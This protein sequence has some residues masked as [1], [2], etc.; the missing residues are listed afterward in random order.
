MHIN[1][2]RIYLFIAIAI[3]GIIFPFVDFLVI[4]EMFYL[5]IPFGIIIIASLIYWI[6]TLFNENLNSKKSFYF[7]LIVPVF[8]L[9]QLFSV[10]TIDK[11]QRFRCNEII[12]DI[13]ELYRA[14]KEYP[15]QYE[16]S[17]GITYELLDNGDRY[18]VS[19]SRGF[20]VTENYYSDI[21]KWKSYGWND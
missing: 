6:M 21:K 17:I 2:N 8:V 10:F 1:I 20:I 3:I 15:E 9:V 12:A 19:Y 7:F 5:L 4:I 14:T 11:I 18:I 16:I 13:E